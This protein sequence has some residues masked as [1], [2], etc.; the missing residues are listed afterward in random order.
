MCPSRPRRPHVRGS[1]PGIQLPC[2]SLLSERIH[3][4]RRWAPQ[5]HRWPRL[6]FLRGLLHTMVKRLNTSSTW[7]IS[8]VLH[9]MVDILCPARHLKWFLFCLRGSEHSMM[10][11]IYGYVRIIHEPSIQLAHHL[12]V[13]PLVDKSTSNQ[14]SIRNLLL[15]IYCH[16]S[17][18]TSNPEKSETC[19]YIYYI[20]TYI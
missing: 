20:Y 12:L 5:F 19:I 2:F 10:F 17:C 9:R 3:N 14:S 15:F 16:Y 1:W 7:L 13:T 4:M 6:C 8:S 11:P 18:E